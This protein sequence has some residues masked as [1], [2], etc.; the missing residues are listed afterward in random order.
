MKTE[1]LQPTEENIAKCAAAL[2]AGE[3]IGMPTETVYGLAGLAFQNE[4]LL[5]IFSSKSRPHFDPLILHV[6]LG[7][8]T[9]AD[10][11]CEGLFNPDEMSDEA[12]RKID[13]LI[14]NFWPGALTLI[15]PKKKI[16]PDLATSGLPSVAVRMPAHPVAIDLIR[17]ADSPLCAPSANQFGRISPTT[18]EATLKEM[19]GKIPYILDGGPCLKGIESTIIEVTE[20]GDVKCLR[21]GSLEIEKI[22]ALLGEKIKKISIDAHEKNL[23]APGQLQNHYAPKKPLYLLDRPLKELNSLPSFF[24]NI[25]NPKKMGLITIQG[26][27]EELRILANE[28][29]EC[30]VYPISLSEKGDWNECAKNLFSS[31]RS[32]DESDCEFIL[33]E[34]ITEKMRL[35]NGLAYAIEDRLKKASKK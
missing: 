22:E 20:D 5:K 18:A 12:I 28:M 16:V 21:L 2:Q 19:D 29:F 4:S 8:A 7:K 23:K 24:Q 11:M 1:I 31:L 33:S 15:L 30:E 17:M 10:L 3:L 25:K 14:R 13:L 6:A 9:T 27:V 34:P 35:E 32:L 26:N